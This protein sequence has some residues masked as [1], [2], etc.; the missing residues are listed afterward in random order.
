MS[1]I[2]SFNPC[3]A[4]LFFSTPEKSSNLVLRFGS[5][6][7]ACNMV[8][9]LGFQLGSHHFRKSCEDQ[10]SLAD[11]VAFSLVCETTSL[12]LDSISACRESNLARVNS[13]ILCL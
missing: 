8:H 3:V 9:R 11:S 1:R 2:G 10:S 13:V 5:G 6:S 4:S 12:I 7:S